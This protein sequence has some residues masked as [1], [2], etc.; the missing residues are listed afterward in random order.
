MPNIPPVSDLKNYSELVSH[1]GSGDPSHLTENGRGKYVVQNIADSEK[2]Q[3]AIWLLSE[4]AKGEESLHK[5]GGLSV[6]AAFA[7]LKG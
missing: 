4:L 5:Y 2:Q 7:G 6:N 3:A 1:C